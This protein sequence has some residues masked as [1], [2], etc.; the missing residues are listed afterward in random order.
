MTPRHLH[1]LFRQLLAIWLVVAG[2]IAPST[3]V[4]ADPIQEN[5]DSSFANPLVLSAIGRESPVQAGIGTAADEDGFQFTAV[6]G[7]TYVIELFNVGASLGQGTQLYYCG[8]AN[9]YYRGMLLAV[10]D[11][12]TN[13]EVA[14]QCLPNGSG[15]VLTSVT[16]KAASSGAYK[17][18]VRAHVTTSVGGYSL[19]VLPKYGEAG[20]SWDAQT[21]EP[22]NSEA[23]AYALALGRKQAITAAIEARDSIYSTHSGDADWYRFEAIQG[24]TYVIE[25]FN[26][27]ASIGQETALYFC[28]GVNNY[29]R[30]LAL[31]VYDTVTK[32]PAALQCQANG[33]GPALVTVSFKAASTGTYTFLV[34]PHVATAIGSYSL[35][36]LPKYHEA[37]ASWDAQTF[38]PNN[39]QANA[40]PITPALASGITAAIEQR[41]TIFST[42]SDDA[43]WYTFQV[44]A[45]ETY[46]VE[47]SNVGGS[48][49]LDSRL[50]FCDGFNNYYQGLRIAAFDATTGATLASRCM[51]NSSGT[52]HTSVTFRAAT[53]G[54]ATVV[55][56]PHVGGEFGPYTLRVLGSVADQPPPATISVTAIQVDHRFEQSVPNA[57]TLSATIRNG[58]RIDLPNV[59][60]TFYLGNPATGGSPIGVATV[61]SLPSGQSRAATYDWT[62]PRQIDDEPIYA[63]ASGAGLTA[64]DTQQVSIFWVPFRV[65][66]DAYSFANNEFTT[67]LRK[68]LEQIRRAGE[69]GWEAAAK[70]LS[71]QLHI[72]RGGV[73]DGMV[74]TAAR[75]FAAPATKPVP[76]L[77]LFDHSIAQVQDP[78]SVVQDWAFLRLF[79]AFLLPPYAETF[80]QTSEGLQAGQPV[81]HYLRNQFGLGNG[82]HLVLA[83]MTIE[84][85][86]QRRVYYY[87]PNT[88]LSAL[89][90]GQHVPYS[91]FTT[92]SF[93]YYRENQALYNR[94]RIVD[95]AQ[96]IR[97]P[98]AVASRAFGL[99]VVRAIEAQ[100][101]SVI[102]LVGDADLL[103]I[104][105]Q[106]RRVGQANG[107]TYQEI[108]NAISYASPANR[109][110]EVPAT[111]TYEVQIHPL[112]GPAQAGASATFSLDVF[113]PL[114][115]GNIEVSAFAS[116]PV[117]AGVARLQLT[118]R[119]PTTP[120]TIAPGAVAQPTTRDVVSTRDQLFL[121]LLRK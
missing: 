2:S 93:T 49:G 5:P 32:S 48:L 112:A 81:A 105:S 55:L 47:V 116:R 33:A 24:Q 39:S 31:F 117:P 73:C 50:Y 104:D 121:P 60:V 109:V 34:Y 29:Y 71:S 85:G 14:L 107:Q 6:A 69:P 96:D 25:I 113:Q 111:A 37:G 120:L 15:E 52:L 7:R 101:R 23:T 41:D 64:T 45:T 20:A 22:N 35:R 28:Q 26:V 53:T 94:V 59:N 3:P 56:F 65:D 58:A 38:E 11:T 92:N 62:V 79:S 67:N 80:A 99:S 42:N 89:K 103:V 13:S 18:R 72:A 87:D 78:I 75:Y 82:S 91:V 8:G 61:P 57:V 90:N 63:I 74:T 19:R 1:R 44:R 98:D 97:E 36:V 43:D 119:A 27:S 9:N 40:F 21:F 86:G 108:P 70:R 114:A 30:G 76:A 17:L 77:S 115:G 4:W 66:R 95:V 54:P 10:F 106:G 46:T 12:V 51:P 110:V 100:Q 84:Q 88:P 16:I 83:F 102:A 68:Q 118:P